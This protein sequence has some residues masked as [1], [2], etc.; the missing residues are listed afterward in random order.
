MSDGLRVL[1]VEEAAAVAERAR[2]Q[3]VQGGI[4]CTY[5]QV[6]SEKDFR[7]VLRRFDPQL[8]LSDLIL[9]GLDGFTALEIA[10]RELPDVP[11]IFLSATP[12]EEHAVEAIRRGA[13]D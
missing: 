4:P 3:L 5:L 10:T 7:L 2:R 9:P 13:A 1:I 12:G 8:I 11:F 6:A